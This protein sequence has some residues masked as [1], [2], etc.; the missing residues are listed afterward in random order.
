MGRKGLSAKQDNSIEGDVFIA[1]VR[2]IK[3]DWDVF[4][5]E[6]ATR[7][8][9]YAYEIT[10]ISREF[11]AL[12]F[13]HR[14]A[15]VKNGIAKKFNART[16]V[17]FQCAKTD[18]WIFKF[19]PSIAGNYQPRESKNQTNIKNKKTRE[20]SSEEPFNAI[21]HPG[22]LRSAAGRR[23]RKSACRALAADERQ[24]CALQRAGIQS[25]EALHLSQMC[26]DHM[27]IL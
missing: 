20:N 16:E 21:T 6:D 2:W 9:I 17:E 18:L 5:T 13:S 26:S 7:K 15:R 4:K 11:R 8:S 27:D 19:A 24:W 10:I 14:L 25:S 3:T 22:R 23:S 1:I 12:G